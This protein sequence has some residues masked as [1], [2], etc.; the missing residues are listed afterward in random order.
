M[1]V[2]V[3]ANVCQALARGMTHL[4]QQGSYEESRAGKVLVSSEPV[5][6]ETIYP[7]QRVL[8]SPVRDANPFFHLYEAIWMLAGHR[9]ADS[10]IHF[11]RD[12][13]IYAE[14][15]GMVHDAY[16]H[17]WRYSFGFDQLNHVVQML[18]KDPT[19]RQAVIQMWDCG[20][21]E[22]LKGNWKTRPCNTH[23]YLR[24][25]NGRLDLTVCCRS[26]DA[27]WGCHG[28]NAV[29]F[30]VLQEYLAARIGVKIG[31]MFQLSNNYH[32]YMDFLQVLSERMFKLMPD[33]Q[34]VHEALV[35]DRYGGAVRPMPMFT[36]PEEIDMDLNVFMKR[37]KQ[38]DFDYKDYANGWFTHTM[39][40]AMLAHAYYK[41]KIYDR[42]WDAA[43]QILA[44]DWAIAC[45]DWIQRRVK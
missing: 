8:F 13:Q 45:T 35:D 40:K 29:H 34:Y 15:D 38:G 24:I 33:C 30:S 3:A 1:K 5:I 6:T 19:T 20:N 17:R 42:A 27:L 44:R 7:D 18:R 31:A 32:A 41:Q 23:I 25:Y 39:G 4:S 22:D 21:A 16:G 11:A 2:I 28:S 9:D 36:K 26:N 14:D 37:Y 12:F 43:N 10:L